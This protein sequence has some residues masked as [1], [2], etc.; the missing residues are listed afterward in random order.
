MDRIISA[1]ILKIQKKK[2]SSH[3]HV[4]VCYGLSETLLRRHVKLYILVLV[5][6]NARTAA[7]TPS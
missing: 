4:I 7:W 3:K 2:C 6:E 5:I 1:F